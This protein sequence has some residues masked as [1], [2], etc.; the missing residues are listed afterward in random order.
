MD[1]KNVA[2]CIE[3][4]NISTRR[5]L[6]INTK[7]QSYTFCERSTSNFPNNLSLSS[8]TLGMLEFLISPIPTLLHP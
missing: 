4:M 7:I 2:I 3:G 8:L 6:V 5:Y 1:E